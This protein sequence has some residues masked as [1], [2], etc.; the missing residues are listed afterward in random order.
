MEPKLVHVMSGEPVCKTCNL[1]P[2]N[3]MTDMLRDVDAG[4]H[5]PED[6]EQLVDFLTTS[7]SGIVEGLNKL[8]PGISAR[9]QATIDEQESEKK[10]IPVTVL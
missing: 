10:L 6:K 5:S 3:R 7:S 4:A 9:A 2:V 8:H 1:D